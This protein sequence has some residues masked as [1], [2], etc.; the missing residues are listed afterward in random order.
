MCVYY[1]CKYYMF[2]RDVVY[3]K[4][5]FCNSQV[6]DVSFTPSPPFCYF[7]PYIK[8]YLYK[9]PKMTHF[10]IMFSI[11]KSNTIT[12]LTVNLSISC[13]SYSKYHKSIS[14]YIYNA[15]IYKIDKFEETYYFHNV[16]L[17][18]V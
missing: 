11:N 5:L 9:C 3:Y 15:S 7:T 10:C 1:L 13:I 16:H 2:S 18:S 6:N 14:L 17:N 8:Y 4:T 12:C